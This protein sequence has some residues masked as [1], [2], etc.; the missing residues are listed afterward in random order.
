MLVCEG[1]P[2]FVRVICDTLEPHG[3]HITLAHEAQQVL[4]ILKVEPIQVVILGTNVRGLDSDALLESIRSLPKSEN[5]PVIL[6][7]DRAD[8]PGVIDGYHS[9]ADLCLAKPLHADDLLAILR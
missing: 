9:G 8:H 2:D 7:F 3:F 1:D 6:I 4:A 5:L